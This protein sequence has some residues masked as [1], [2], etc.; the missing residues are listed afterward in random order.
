GRSLEDEVNYGKLRDLEVA[1]FKKNV[2]P[3]LEKRVGLIYKKAFMQVVEADMLAKGLVKAEDHWQ[4][5]STEDRVQVGVKCIELLIEST[6]LVELDRVNAG[7]IGADAENIKL[8]DKYADI[9]ATR[10]SALA[11]ISP[12]HQPCV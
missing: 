7:V 1:N 12:I 6:G 3:Q 11:G 5:W 4:A 2:Q 9:I 10:A 8:S